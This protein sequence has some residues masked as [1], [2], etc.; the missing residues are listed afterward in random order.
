MNVRTRFAPSPTGFLHIGGART[1]LFNWL[2]ARHHQG[3]FILRI[4]DSDQQRSTQQSIDAILQGMEW[5]GLDYDEPLVYQSERTARYQTVI[6]QLLASGHAYYCYTSTE[7]LDTLRNE[8][9]ERGEKPRY[10]GRW[11]DNTQTPPADIKPVVRFK[12]PQE[13]YI[14]YMD[15]IH[16][17]IT[18][19]N[20]ELDDLVIARADG[21]PTYNL[22]VV[23]DDIDM[24]I[25]HI[26]RGD[27]HINNTPRQLHIYQALSATPP[28]FAHTPMVLGN[29]GTRLSKR[30]GAVSVLAYQE[31]GYLPEAFI[32][33]LARL[34][35]S[36]GN[37]EVFS[38]DELIA[39][40]DIQHI[41]KSAAS[42]DTDKLNW[43]NTTYLKT[44]TFTSIR[45]DLIAQYQKIGINTDFD[46][47]P[48]Q[49]IF[50]ALS[51][52]HHTLAAI[53]A[54]S[55]YFMQDI[56]LDS[57]LL[58]KHR[59]PALKA[60]L[61]TLS[62]NLKTLN[63]WE[64]DAIFSAIKQIAKAHTLKVGQIGMPIRLALSGVENTPSIGLIAMLLG[65]EKT[66][67]RI[68]NCA[69]LL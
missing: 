51:D 31:A 54:N 69:A 59:N 11:R 12:T 19:A 55:L 62:A 43:L 47:L 10:D 27:D 45:N 13:G 33:Q 53:A 52:R 16:G 60:A 2:Y 58:D 61:S 15:A 37:Q 23:V 39:L 24:A 66:L 56:T 6:Q 63:D 9:I 57:H 22:T 3:T 7:E 30:H 36:H 25:T 4:E 50:N 5:L 38:R 8:Q 35:W 49:A 48:L 34:G 17:D 65:K 28:I 67:Q 20:S 42:F 1:A 40:F 46:A 14:S 26:I 64:E 29:D 68:G 21:S 41:N 32:N 44:C 18:I